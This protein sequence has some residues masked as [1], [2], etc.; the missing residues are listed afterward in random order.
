[1]AS[2]VG[3]RVE[4]KED[5]KL[6]TGR[7]KYTA[8]VNF[9][10]Q[11]YA[12]FV[13]SP[14]A[15]AAIKKVDTSK[16]LKSS[17]VISVLTG[18][19]IANDK[20]GGLIAGWRIKSEDGSDMK[21]PAHPALAN[22]TV[23]YVGDHVAVVIA[24]SLDE[25]RAA[26]DLVKVDYKVL[27]AVVETE[28]AMD[29]DVIHKDIPKNLCYDWLL[30]DRNKTKE[31]FDNADKII[32]IDLRNNRLIPNAMEPRAAVG[33]FNPSTEE[34]TLYTANQNPHLT[35]LV[36]SAFN[37]VAPEHKFRVV[38]PDVGGGFGSKIYP[39]SED[40]V[41]S[42]ASKKIQRPVKW[43]AQRTE[44]F[45][46]DCHGRDHITHAELAV[47]SDG[48]VVGLKV[49][50]IA[51]LGGYASLFA[52]VT[53]TYLYGPLV[54]GLYDIP[55]A[56]CNVKAVYT[57]TAPVDAYRGAGR[58]E[59]A[60]L[61][62]R[63]VTEGAKEIGMD[64][65]EF[66]KKNFIN[67]FPH[68]QCLVH[69]I[70]S[71]DYDAHLDKA[72]ELSDYKN[73]ENRR[74]QSAKKGKLRGIG[75]STYFEAC[76]VAPSAVVMSI[77]AGVGLWE[78]AEVRFN[79][80][81]NISVFTGTHS[82]G[83]SHDTTFAQIVGDK[84]G[85]P[86][87]NIDIVHGDTDKGPFGMGTYGSRSLAVGGTAIVNACDKIIAKGKKVA[88]KMLEG[89]PEDI[90]FKAGE[91]ILKNSNK[92]K[93]IGEIAFA[94]YLPG[95]FGDVKSPLPDGVEP[96]LIETSF[97]DPSNFSFPSGSHI[98]EVEIDEETGETKLVKYTVVDD[99]GTVINPLVVEGQ[100]YGGVAQGVGQA[101]YE[102]AHYDES[103]QLTSA[104]YMDYTM[105][106][107]DNFPQIAIDYTCTPATSNPL[108]AKGCGEAGTIAAPAAVMNAVIDAVGT[109]IQMPATAEKVWKALKKNGSKKAAA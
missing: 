49:D 63:I 52:T 15:R 107:A 38:A 28:S 31:A 102:N 17:G 85:V 72:I 56:Y 93:T 106:R 86:I 47:K 99:F 7:G 42:W 45:L 94:C 75:F 97:F 79:P 32:K 81:G 40:V 66:R 62:E 91:F 80:T 13:R 24:E 22:E 71:G 51:N 53:P 6:L 5:K 46:S 2:L 100:V 20:I 54:L 105:P 12:Y 83:Q 82:H 11:T 74:S 41:I 34:I 87:E 57:N 77:G 33:D 36:I 18:A 30:G 84:L 48:K 76:G 37:A 1:M 89:K 19:D 95:T 104:S 68:Q 103:G 88:A 109:D 98:C 8:D 69:N 39:Y 61:I 25:A 14:H 55:A 23:N 16:A 101:L 9:V 73:F 96:G 60:F 3:S 78:S 58:P 64:Q 108:G 21:V 4:R 43:V 44:S 92:K 29:S 27:K 10:N 67:K 90:D 59:A 65:A 50:T 26:A 70:D 35:R